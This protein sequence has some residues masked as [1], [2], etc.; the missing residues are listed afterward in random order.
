MSITNTR[1]Y[2]YVKNAYV[3]VEKYLDLQD[4]QIQN[5]EGLKSHVSVMVLNVKYVEIQVSNLFHVFGDLEMIPMGM[6]LTSLAAG[7]T[8]AE[9]VVGKW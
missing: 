9:N 5:Q 3:G 6:Y 2:F 7:R 8:H 1:S 4:L